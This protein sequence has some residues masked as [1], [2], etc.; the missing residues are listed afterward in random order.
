MVYLRFRLYGLV[1]AQ[2]RA[3]FMQHSLVA[4]CSSR[5]LAVPRVRSE[6]GAHGLY[7]TRP[8]ITAAQMHAFTSVFGRGWG[9]LEVKSHQAMRLKPRLP[10]LPTCG[11]WTRPGKGPSRG[12]FVMR[13][14][15]C[16]VG[17]CGLMLCSN[18][19]WGIEP[20]FPASSP[21]SPGTKTGLHE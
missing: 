6:L 12:P 20:F 14:E 1:D 18:R 8:D 4:P 2:K 21:A 10:I 11:S 3:K 15:H 19:S 9:G 13:H 16:T 7:C 5:C 17:I